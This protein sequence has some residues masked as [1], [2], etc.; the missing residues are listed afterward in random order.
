MEGIQ[1]E[2]LLKLKNEKG[3]NLAISKI[4]AIGFEKFKKNADENFG[5]LLVPSKGIVKAEQKFF[6]SINEATKNRE[7][8]GKPEVF[9]EE[10]YI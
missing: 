4:S 9:D 3:H 1:R 8:A 10:L 5:E 6:D 7:N 2:R